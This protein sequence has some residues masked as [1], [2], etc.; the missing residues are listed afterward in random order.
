MN[1][2]ADLYSGRSLQRQ[3]ST[4]AGLY[5]GRSLQRQVSTAAG[6]YSGR[7]LQRQIFGPLE[8][9]GLQLA[10]RI[11]RALTVDVAGQDR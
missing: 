6:L 1:L 8:G 3:V 10:Q 11:H 2:E 7:S 9:S 4:A 5:S